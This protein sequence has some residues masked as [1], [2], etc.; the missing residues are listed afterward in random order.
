MPSQPF[1]HILSRLPLLQGSLLKNKRTTDNNFLRWTRQWRTEVYSSSQTSLS[2]KKKSTANF[3]KTKVANRPKR[4]LLKFRADPSYVRGVNVRSKF[5]EKSFR[6]ARRNLNIIA[7][8]KI[9]TATYVRTYVRTY[10]CTYVRTYVRTY[11]C[12]HVR[13]WPSLFCIPRLRFD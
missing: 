10:V 1:P 11:V 5:R 9:N 12:T 2:W 8:Y 6:G 4:I 3:C 13:T 7:G